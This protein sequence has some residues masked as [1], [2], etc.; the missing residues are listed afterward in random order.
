MILSSSELVLVIKNI[1]KMNKLIIDA[2]KDKIFLMIINN[3]TNYSITHKNTKINYEKLTLLIKEF[4]KLKS[5]PK[6]KKVKKAIV[7]TVT[8][9]NEDNVE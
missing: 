5:I 3:T 9:V 6:I 4:L 1:C 7:T 8:I 2:T